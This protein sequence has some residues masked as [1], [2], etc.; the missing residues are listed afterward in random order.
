MSGYDENFIEF[1]DTDHNR[2]PY[3]TE[4]QWEKALPHFLE[5]AKTE[6][7]QTSPVKRNQRWM[8]KCAKRHH[9]VLTKAPKT[10]IRNFA[11]NLEDYYLNGAVY[12][13]SNNEEFNNLRD[14]RSCDR[15]T[16][17]VRQERISQQYWNT[18]KKIYVPT[19]GILKYDPD[20]MDIP[21]V[22]HKVTI[23]RWRSSYKK[24]AEY[25]NTYRILLN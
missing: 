24:K 13:L 23:L 2:H 15:I 14:K 18:S 9:K 11:K 10:I 5:R 16:F 7:H 19:L 3:F 1:S 20:G 12:K 25:A 17:Y 21:P 22:L 8:S 4:D 6:I